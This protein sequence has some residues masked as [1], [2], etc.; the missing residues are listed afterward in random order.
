MQFGANAR[1][2]NIVPHPTYLPSRNPK[3]RSAVTTRLF[4]VVLLA[5]G[6][7]LAGCDA[8]DSQADRTGK[9]RGSQKAAKDERSGPNAGLEKE[10]KAH[11]GE[12]Q[13]RSSGASAQYST[14]PEPEEVLASQYEHINADAY[15]VA[16]DLFDDQSQRAISLEEYKAYFA[17]VAPYE[18]TGYSFPSVRIQGGTA[19]VVVD[20]E[21]SSSEGEDAYTVTQRLVREDGD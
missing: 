15:G 10:P 13:P 4:F 3:G 2:R 17:S 12:S 5:V 9:E 20:L 16:Y 21:V 14:G 18:I 19:S 8:P 1:D 6:L 7:V 11:E